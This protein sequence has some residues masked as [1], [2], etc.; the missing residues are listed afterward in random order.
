M[1]LADPAGSRVILVGTSEYQDD[2]LPDIAPV[3]NNVRALA[4]IF[5]DPEFGAL[6]EASCHTLINAN[7]HEATLQI[8]RWCREADDVL[9]VYFSGHGLIGNNGELLLAFTDTDYGL[10][11]FSA[12]PVEQLRRALFDSPA[13]TKVLI[14]DCCYSGRAIPTMAAADATV[15]GQVEV[16]GTYTLTS[17]PRDLQSLYREGERF[18]VFSGALISVLRNGV[19]GAPA[20]LSVDVIYRNLL[21][22]LRAEQLPEP[23]QL[24]SDTAGDL[25]LVHNAAFDAKESRA[26]LPQP[27]TAKAGDIFRELDDLVS[28]AS[29]DTERQALVNASR[30]SK[31]PLLA[32]LRM[33]YELARLGDLP[34]AVTSLS[35]LGKIT[36]PADALKA[37]VEFGGLMTSNRLWSS[38]YL[39]SWD[40]SNL[41]DDPVALWGLLMAM[42]LRTSGLPFKVRMEAAT[43]LVRYGKR[44]EAGEILRGM[45]RQQ[46]LLKVEREMLSTRIKSV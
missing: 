38:A 16:A 32:R 19:S 13:R 18:T 24:H 9:V 11:E 46:G 31:W 41:D 45:A 14:L 2:N 5:R 43:D 7:R 23:R 29:K 1:R 40:V 35:A 21:R 33:T 30:D 25:A 22:R 17:A 3:A 8:A 6:D 39:D 44:R 36:Q 20:L 42:W 26:Q 4:S 10:S 37:L 28:L 34:S 12:L 27:A 15:L